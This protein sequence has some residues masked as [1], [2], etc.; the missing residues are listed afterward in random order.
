MMFSMLSGVPPSTSRDGSGGDTP[1]VTVPAWGRGRVPRTSTT[2]LPLIFSR[3]CG[4][5]ICAISYFFYIVRGGGGGGFD[6]GFFEAADAEGAGGT[7]H[8]FGGTRHQ[9]L[10]KVEKVLAGHLNEKYDRNLF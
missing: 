8:D 6:S 1:A 4:H 7:V 5:G 3:R 2:S 10:T 9:A